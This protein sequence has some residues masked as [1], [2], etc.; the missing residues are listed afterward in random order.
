MCA[1]TAHSNCCCRQKLQTST[2]PRRPPIAFVGSLGYV[3]AGWNHAVLPGW[4]LGY[5]YLP[6]TIGIA[7]MAFIMAPLGVMIAHRLPAKQLKQVFGGVLLVV[8]SRMLW[9][10]F[11]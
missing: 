7:S 8:A 3:L 11:G 10:S 2:R 9:S 6:A 4:T 5:V 1:T